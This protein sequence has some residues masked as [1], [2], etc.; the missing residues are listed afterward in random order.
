MSSNKES[1]R[2]CMNKEG[3]ILNNK[4]EILDRW[5]DS[6]EDPLKEQHGE[7]ICN[8]YNMD[9]LIETRHEGRG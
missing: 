3:N 5:A 8:T 4:Q 2:S 7:R 9:G 1:G 6:F